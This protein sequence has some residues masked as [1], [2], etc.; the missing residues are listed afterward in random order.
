MIFPS[1]SH[2]PPEYVGALK[3]IGERLTTLCEGSRAIE[4]Y[5]NI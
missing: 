4:T 5:V 2:H 1:V 3:K